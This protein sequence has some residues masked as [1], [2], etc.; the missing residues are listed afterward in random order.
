MKYTVCIP[1]YGL[2]DPDH[3]AC[4]EVLKKQGDAIAIV[5]NCPY[6]DMARCKLGKMFTYETPE[7]NICMFIDHDIIFQPP[8][9]RDMCQRLEDSDYDILGALYCH[10]RP[11]QGLIGH[12]ES[13]IKEAVFYHPGL[14]PATVLGM[15]FT[16]I[17]RRVF[18]ELKERCPLVFCPTLGEDVHPYFMGML[19]TS[20]LIGPK[21]VYW[22]GEDV[23]FLVRA[24]LAGFKVGIDLQPRIFHRGK[25]DY[26]IEDAAFDSAPNAPSVRVTWDLEPKT[27]H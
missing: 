21:P 4:V 11:A 27:Q 26:A 10:R 20:R 24:K 1:Y 8:E 14:I 19:D 23:S 12:P 5:P 9:V 18:E 15:G 16:A 6:V 7:S 13:H 22:H 3:Q 25:K 2:R 17:K